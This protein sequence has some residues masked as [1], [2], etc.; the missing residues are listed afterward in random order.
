MT[1]TNSIFSSNSATYSGSGGG[2]GGAIFNNGTMTV[3]SATFSGNTGKSGGSIRNGSTLIVS[4]S[5]FTQNSAIDRG[6]AIIHNGGTTT[7][8][9]STLNNNSTSNGSGGAISTALGGKFSINNSTVSSN[10][11]KFYGGGIEDSNSFGKTDFTI[12]NSTFY[13]NTAVNGGS[14]LSLSGA[15]TLTITNTILVK[16]A[17][18]GNCLIFS[19]VITGNSSLA[20]DNSCPSIANSSNIKLDPTLRN[21]GGST[22]THALLSGSDALDTGSCSGTT[23]DQR[24]FSRPVDLPTV[25]NTDDGCDIGAYEVGPYLTLTKTVSPLVPKPG[26]TI[27][28][29]IVISNNSLVTATN[30]QVSD[31]LSP[32]LYFVGPIVLNP[33]NAGILGNSGTL[34]ALV[35]NLT[36]TAG[37]QIRLTFPVT[38]SKDLAGGQIISNTAS[39]T[40]TEVSIPITGQASITVANLPAITITKT[41]NKETASVGETITYTYYV[42]NTGNAI[43]MNLTASDT[44]LGSIPL[45]QSTLAPGEGATGSL[46]YTIVEADLPGPITNTAAVTGTSISGD[47]TATAETSVNLDFNAAITIAKTANVETVA[48]GDAITYTYFVTNVG[49]VSL[50]NLTALDTPLGPIPLDKNNLA[51]GHS[52]SGILTYTISEA[53]LP[54][55][56][57]NTVVVTGTSLSNKIVTATTIISVT[58]ESNSIQQMYLP[59]ILKN[60]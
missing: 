45:D 17:T 2:E 40:S 44:P 47:I 13:S 52:A 14:S 10:S 15:G 24:G 32:G 19:G 42:T 29:T 11:A 39:V 46:T 56:T 60:R 23:I 31:P 43:L 33:Q 48:V 36:I 53:D 59:L 21:N 55:P 4:Q 34:P 27:T 30:A 9:N 20:D 3:Y 16:G 37:E 49:N 25:V 6:G 54:G 35:S 51:P 26:D 7:V 50:T 58:L 38:I 57:T 12:S 18:G 1:I 28:Y 8:T 41:V 22:W 5:T